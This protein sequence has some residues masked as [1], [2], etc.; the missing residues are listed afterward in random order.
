MTPHRSMSIERAAH[1]LLSI[2]FNVLYVA[3]REVRAE[4]SLVVRPVVWLKRAYFD[5]CYGHYAVPAAFHS[6]K[7]PQVLITF[8]QVIWCNGKRDSIGGRSTLYMCVGI[9]YVVNM[10]ILNSVMLRGFE[11]IP[12]N[13]A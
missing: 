7:S 2:M 1:T 8:P 12:R 4:Q 13:L 3:M 6:A 10:M 9:L 5:R 11:S